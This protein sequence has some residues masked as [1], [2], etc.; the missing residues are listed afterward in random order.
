MGYRPWTKDCLKQEF[1]VYEVCVDGF[2]LGKYEVTQGE[3]KQLMRSNNSRFN[4]GD[5]YTVGQKAPNGLAICDVSGKWCQ[6]D[7]NSN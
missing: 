7:L 6:D 4:M 1:P 2:W 5:L 3:W